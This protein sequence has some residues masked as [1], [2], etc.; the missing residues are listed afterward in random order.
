LPPVLTLGCGS[1]FVAG[2]LAGLVLSPWLT[3]EDPAKSG[4]DPGA[5]AVTTEPRDR[6]ALTREVAPLPSPL[7]P[8]DAPLPGRQQEPPAST[9]ILP[10]PPPPA[11]EV[12]SAVGESEPVD[13]LTNL[14]GRGLT[15]P[16]LGVRRED[17]RDSFDETRG[18]DRRHEAIDILAPRG[19]PVLAVEDGTIAK[20][21]LS[22]GGGGKTIYQFDDDG[23]YAYYYA[24]LDRYAEGLT[25]G[26]RV[27]RAQVI[28]YVG[29]S[30]NAP[31][32][33]PHLH[34]AVYLLE[35]ERNWWEGD[36]VNPFEILRPNEPAPSR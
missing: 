24:H 28:G 23:L 4:V 9:E 27:H 30:G 29:T 33:T 6:L 32:D 18:N 1:T 8:I 15:V 26:A 36:P 16:V 17:L 12:Q 5:P 22:H 7:E 25:E 21:F 14:I 19:T 20:L 31:P 10:S 3:R 35:A 2:L 34:F 11:P 13:P